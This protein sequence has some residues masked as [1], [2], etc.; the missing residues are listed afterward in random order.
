[1]SRVLVIDDE[2]DVQAILTDLLAGRGLEVVTAGD[3]EEG[4]ARIQS[5]SPSIVLL[6][7]AMPKLTGMEVLARLREEHSRVPVIVVTAFADVPKVVE[8]MRL[9]AWDY[10]TKPF[11]CDEL[12]LRIQQ[13]LERQAL[14]AE[15]EALRGEIGAGGLKTQMGPSE[16]VRKLAEQVR[17][18]ATSNFSVLVEGETGTGKELV[19]RAIHRQSAR[20]DG[21]FVALDCGAMPET[22]IE[23]ELFGYEKGAFTGA[24]RRKDGYFRLAEGGTL[25]LDEVANLPTAVQSK[26]LRALQEREILVLGGKQPLRVDV[27]IIAASNVPLQG[28]V[29]ASR[30]RQDLYYR[31]NEFSVRVPPL[32]ERRED[33]LYLARRFLEEVSMELR[34]GAA[35]LSDDAVHL[36]LRYSW[37]GNARELKN[38][39]RRAA[40]LSS[41]L[42]TSEHLMALAVDADSEPPSD[43]PT[44]APRPSL[45]LREAAEAAVAQAEQE[46]IRQALAATRGNKSE[47]AR[48]LRT[49]YK[50]L[51]LK[52][53]RYGITPRGLPSGAP[54]SRTG[55]TRETDPDL[56]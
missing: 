17:L 35:E 24:D 48:L 38:V 4:L 31:L 42:V 10:V 47:A 37:P 19:A 3:G 33:I 40:L 27:R 7:L 15:V 13:V 8:A 49:D 30:F 16:Q 20:R 12:L 32:R 2:P 21:R 9:G 53:R 22:L 28:E 6:D 39:I 44:R 41:G 56:P 51:H 5:D 45:S 43:A 50:T 23:S 55:A 29:R 54:R 25:F 14:I 26:L 52:I 18:V 11:N 46:A 1:V 34:C 36:L